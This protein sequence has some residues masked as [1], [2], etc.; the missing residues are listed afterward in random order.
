MLHSEK[1][2]ASIITFPIKDGR[3]GFGE[4]IVDHIAKLEGKRAKITI[5]EYH[6]PR[7]NKQNRYYWGVVLKYYQEYFRKE[8]VYFT[9][10][11]AHDWIKEHVWGDLLEGVIERVSKDGEVS[12]IPYRKLL[13]STLLTTKEW[14]LRMT[15]S[16]QYAAEHLNMQIPEPHEKLD[17]ELLKWL[18]NPEGVYYMEDYR[19][20]FTISDAKKAK[21]NSK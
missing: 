2:S 5:E 17:E 4:I 19:N 13:S 16:R 9:N 18:N 21:K 8:Q 10:D 1:Q 11:E 3:T 6:S 7:T 12:H 15:A 14:E 20:Y